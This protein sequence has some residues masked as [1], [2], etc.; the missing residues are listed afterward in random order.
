MHALS[1]HWKPTW[2][3]VAYFMAPQMPHLSWQHLERMGSGCGR[4]WGLARRP[5]TDRRPGSEP[6]WRRLRAVR[7]LKLAQA[8]RNA[9]PSPLV[10]ITALLRRNTWGQHGAT[11]SLIELGVVGTKYEYS[12]RGLSIRHRSRALLRGARLNQPFILDWIYKKIFNLVN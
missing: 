12:L 11:A 7:M 5:E 9:S 6:T 3:A 1:V 10:G 8:L 4:S 2:A